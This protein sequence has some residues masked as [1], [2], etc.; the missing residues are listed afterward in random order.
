MKVTFA[1][2]ARGRPIHLSRPASYRPS[3]TRLGRHRGQRRS[4]S[5]TPRFHRKSLDACA[6][7]P[8]T[9]MRQ[10][11]PNAHARRPQ[12]PSAHTP[13]QGNNTRTRMRQ[14]PPDAHAPRS[15]QPSAHA[16]VHKNLVRRMQDQDTPGA[17]AT[18]AR[19]NTSGALATTVRNVR[20]NGCAPPV[21]RD[22]HF[23]LV[24]RCTGPGWRDS[25]PT[26]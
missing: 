7:S 12:Q 13:A 21:S 1:H 15:R 17:L 4:S 19:K 16:P 25:A 23:S 11:P 10:A 14:V 8:P 20:D 6:T 5:R 18:A 9:R 24:L 3:I 2:R 26:Q 22:E